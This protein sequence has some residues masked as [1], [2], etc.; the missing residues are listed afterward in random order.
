MQFDC[1]D[2]DNEWVEF[3]GVINPQ[4]VAIPIDSLVT[5]MGKSHLGVGWTYN[6]G[7]IKSMYPAFFTKKPVRS[8]RSFLVPRG[9]L[10]YD[11]RKDRYVV[12]N[13]DKLKNNMLPGTLT[14]L[15]RGSC[16][17]SQQGMGSFPIADRHLLSQSFI[18]DIST[19]SD[20]MVLRGGLVLDMP[21]PEPTLD[22]L[23]TVIRA[24]DK[25]SSATYPW[26]TTN[27]CRMSF[28][29]WMTP[30][31]LI[32]ELDLRDEY[33]KEVPKEARQRPWCSM[34]GVALRPL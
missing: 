15:S 30:D 2:F 22:Y 26:A 1:D 28:W 6:D 25:A 18:G 5:E 20:Q 34:D 3:T 14:Q 23:T 32:G 8:D 10:R 17:V 19:T 27:T 24:S 16:V 21:M 13:D 29:A 33:K 7:G 12:T 4:D 11:K 31:P 9:Y